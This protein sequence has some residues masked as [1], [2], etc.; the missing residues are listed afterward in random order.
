MGAASGITVASTRLQARFGG[1]LVPDGCQIE[2]FNPAAVNRE[3][4][5]KQ[6]G[7]RGPVV[8]FPGRR[9]THKGLKPLAK[10]VAQILG[11]RLAVLCRPDDFSQPEWA[12]FPLI[13][14]PI[15]P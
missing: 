13:K 6:F 3:E 5:R 9:R 14:I 10:S 15:I 11:A 4:A 1:T 8:L 2:Q 12:S 7:F